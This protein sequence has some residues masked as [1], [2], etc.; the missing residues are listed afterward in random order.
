[1][2]DNDVTRGERNNNP[3]NLNYIEVHPWQGQIGM[4]RV[5]DGESYVPRFG[6]YDCAENG[7]RAVAKQLLAYQ[8]HHNCRTVRDFVQRWAPPQENETAAYIKDVCRDTGFAQDETIDLTNASNLA[9]LTRAIIKH[10]NG[11]F[12]YPALM[13]A[14]AAKAALA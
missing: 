4:E 10:E 14:D 6:R 9:A 5:P 1:M 11:R 12:A 8:Q 7:I 13:V 2:N 3:G